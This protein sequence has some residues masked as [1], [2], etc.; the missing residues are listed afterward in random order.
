MSAVRRVT[1]MAIFQLLPSVW[2]DVDRPT[3]PRRRL[4][5]KLHSSFLA[6]KRSTRRKRRARSALPATARAH[7]DQDVRSTCVRDRTE[8]GERCAQRSSALV[9]DTSKACD[10]AWVRVESPQIP[11][12]GSR[13]APAGRASRQPPL[14]K[15][16]CRRLDLLT[17]GLTVHDRH[18]FPWRA[19]LW[20]R[21]GNLGRRSWPGAR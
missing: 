1:L 19:A 8:L 18:G 11:P 5:V 3:L 7:V 6:G 20:L 21:R 17:G 9:G 12:Q 2:R 15:K 10:R 14:Q 4:K 16:S 13:R